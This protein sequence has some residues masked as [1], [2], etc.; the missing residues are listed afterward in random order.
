MSDIPK[1]KLP[2]RDDGS[3]RP[4]QGPRNVS[5]LSW[6]QHE[7]DD[8]NSQLQKRLLR[9]F[10]LAVML[11]ALFVMFRD[12]GKQRA[13]GMLEQITEA[14]EGK[15]PALPKS[16]YPSP[17]GQS[18]IQL[19]G[20][21][22]KPLIPVEEAPAAPAGQEAKSPEQTGEE[23]KSPDA[24]NDEEGESNPATPH[25]ETAQTK[26]PGD[27]RRMFTNKEGRQMEFQGLKAE[28]TP[29]PELN[30][31][32]EDWED[33]FLHV[34][35]EDLKSKRGL[36]DANDLT[37]ARQVLHMFIRYLR[38]IGGDAVKL[39]EVEKAR[40]AALIEKHGRGAGVAHFNN[41]MS[42]HYRDYRGM[43]YLFEGS[44]IR[45]YRIYNWSADQENNSGVRYTWLLICRDVKFK[46]Y[47]VL[48][49]QDVRNI[50]SKDDVENPDVI[51]WHGLFMQRWSFVRQDQVWDAMPLYAALE[52]KRLELPDSGTGTWVLAMAAAMVV[53]LYFLL[54]QLRRDEA[55]GEQVLRK[56][57][58]KPG[59][60]KRAG[61]EATP[62]GASPA[63]STSSAPEGTP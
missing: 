62:D 37:E 9:M 60:G 56:M 27:D 51:S 45:K 11:A 33:A 17:Q 55:S 8:E 23:A 59:A 25:G 3:R 14:T 12:K 52:V 13:E 46:Q 58:R 48:V 10:V 32:S 57:R 47:A 61:G 54:R 26:T 42:E 50:M 22:G 1:F 35:D 30:P 5:E 21:D 24:E 38:T 36:S 7:T 20:P 28:F 6:M 41:V 53:G 19:T 43:P 39:E 29:L 4:G 34:F 40:G 2:G 31:E 15:E 63:A 16:A 18:D 44:L 49:P